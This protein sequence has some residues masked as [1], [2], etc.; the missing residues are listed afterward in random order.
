MKKLSALFNERNS[1]YVIKMWKSYLY[2]QLGTIIIGFVLMIIA[3]SLE[4][5]AVKMLQPVF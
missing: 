1:S 3:S 5:I 2:P 4:A